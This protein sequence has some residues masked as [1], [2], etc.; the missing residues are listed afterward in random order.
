MRSTRAQR[1]QQ[2]DG[3]PILSRAAMEHCAVGPLLLRHVECIVVLLDEGDAA[4][5][6]RARGELAGEPHRQAVAAELL[7]VDGAHAARIGDV[8]RRDLDHCK[9][10]LAAVAAT[11]LVLREYPF[12]RKI[13]LG[14][15]AIADHGQ[16]GADRPCRGAAEPTGAARPADACPA[17]RICHR[18]FPPKISVICR[19]RWA[20]AAFYPLR[21]SGTTLF[22]PPNALHRH[23]MRAYN[24][25]AT[26]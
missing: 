18:P 3:G 9:L 20:I 23:A 15:R 6:D 25:P 21:A 13:A 22:G 1:R 14:E 5:E 17:E 16:G 26:A 12:D 10:L 19:R 7:A 4:R 11:D 2:F 8:L 24:T